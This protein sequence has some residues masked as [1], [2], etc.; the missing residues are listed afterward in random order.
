MRVRASEFLGR[1]V[2]LL[3]IYRHLKLTNPFQL[4][5]SEGSG[6]SQPASPR[7]RSLLRPNYS[8]ITLPYV[9]RLF[10]PVLGHGIDDLRSYLRSICLLFAS[11]INITAYHCTVLYG[12]VHRN[13]NR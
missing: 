9:T 5:S 12:K 8:S 7:P 3:R 2:G 6:R 1:G 11:S 13:Q 10:D 4:L